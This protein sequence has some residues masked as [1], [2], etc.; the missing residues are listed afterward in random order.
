MEPEHSSLLLARTPTVEP[1]PELHGVRTTEADPELPPDRRRLVCLRLHWET[2]RDDAPFTDPAGVL[3][4]LARDD[5]PWTR[6]DLIWSLRVLATETGR[7][8][9]SPWRLPALIGAALP[10]GDLR[11]LQPAIETVLDALKTGYL[12]VRVRHSLSQASP[13]AARTSMSP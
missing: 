10:A 7:D 11:E 12:R 4:A 13:A 3:Q 2:A 1:D 9:G 6:D 5:V 8:D